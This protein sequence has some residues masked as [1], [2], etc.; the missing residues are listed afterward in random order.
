MNCQSKKS[1]ASALTLIVVAACL[2]ALGM[3]TPAQAQLSREGLPAD[4]NENLGTWLSRGP[5]KVRG[6]L[7]VGW[8][9]R[10]NIFLSEDNTVSDNIMEIRPALAVHHDFTSTS[11]WALE[12]QGTFAFYQDNTGNDWSSHY[13]PFDF[14]LGGKTGPFVEVS[15]D[16]W[17]SD[18]PYGSQDLYNLG[19]KTKRTQNDAYI[20][21]GWTFSEKTKAQV[22]ARYVYLQYDE[23]RD[24]WQ[25]QREWNWG[26]KFFYKFMP[27]TSALFQYTYVTR[28]YPDQDS[29]FAQDFYRNDFYV[30]LV[31]D[32][33]S[34]LTGEAKVGYSFMDYDNQYNSVGQ[35][36]QN[37]DTWIAAVNLS[38]QATA[39]LV[40]TGG[41]ERAI[42]Q[43]T[44]SMSGSTYPNNYYLDTNAS[45]GARYS[46][47]NNLT[48]FAMVLAGLNDYNSLD[49]TDAR[50]D[51][52]FK[53]QI[54]LEYSFLRHL[55]LTGSYLYDYR[56]SNKDNLSYTDNVFYVGL[57]GRF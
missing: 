41:L 57:G 35:E 7:E 31:W 16:F 33:T 38:W 54:G 43:S 17:R 40:L 28:E 13:I 48:A 6:G 42:R 36:Y 21:P 49:G 4:P 45:V 23:D 50:E 46:I 14:F 8:K 15:N 2:F 10:S 12:Y 44:Q 3:S 27:K 51:D 9:N 55:Y 19:I 20:S 5:L 18:D 11:F 34:K 29:S 53:G 25:N 26:G 22:Y 1:L 52:V 30:G 32:A 24:E 39:R 47:L 56:D 37:K